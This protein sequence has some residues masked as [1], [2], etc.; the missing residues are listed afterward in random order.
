[1]RETRKVL[2]AHHEDEYVAIRHEVENRLYPQA[3]ETWEERL[4]AGIRRAK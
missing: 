4:A 2:K 1:M 3:L